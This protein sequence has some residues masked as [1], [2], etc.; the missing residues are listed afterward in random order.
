MY[1]FCV[2]PICD[3]SNGFAIEFKYVLSRFGEDW[4]RLTKDLLFDGEGSLKFKPDLWMDI[5]KV[6]LPS[7][8]DQVSSHVL[9]HESVTNSLVQ[10]GY[11]PIPRIEYTD[12]QLD[13]VIENLALSGRNLF[14][15][16][17]SMEAHN[18]VK[19]SPYNA[20]KYVHDVLLS[21]YI[22]AY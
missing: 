4:A 3:F 2:W 9:R 14:P 8:I 5:R 7:I 17:V 15:N 13:L 6:I 10:V 16:I 21:T 20:I 12:D 19:F 11:V 22:L 18:F 1:V